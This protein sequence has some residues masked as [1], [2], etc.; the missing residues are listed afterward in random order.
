MHKAVEAQL[1]NF[2]ERIEETGKTRDEK[3]RSM[4]PAVIQAFA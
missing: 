2:H 4:M 3:A 1:K